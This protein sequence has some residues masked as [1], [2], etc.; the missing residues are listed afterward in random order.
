MRAAGK[1]ADE[2]G[3]TREARF[4]PLNPQQLGE[5]LDAGLQVYATILEPGETIVAPNGWWH[6]AVSLTPTITLMCNFWDQARR[7]V[8]VAAPLVHPSP[9]PGRVLNLIAPRCVC[10]QANVKGLHRMLLKDLKAQP[11]VEKLANRRVY[12]VA[13][14]PYVYIREGPSR[15]QRGV[16]PSKAFHTECV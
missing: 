12:S 8:R 11:C 16:T 13:H 2:G 5:R 4:D 3:T 9:T 1:S 6:Y 15:T 14:R 7:V 10:H